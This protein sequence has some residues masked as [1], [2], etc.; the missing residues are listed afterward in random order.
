MTGPACRL[1]RFGCL[2]VTG[3]GRLPSP[4]T[5]GLPL[6][7]LPQVPWIWIDG[8][9]RDVIRGEMNG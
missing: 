4:D 2:A 6:A 1:S 5:G 9:R 7:G 8:W 3:A